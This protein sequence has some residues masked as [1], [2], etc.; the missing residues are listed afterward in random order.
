MYLCL[1]GGYC[2]FFAGYVYCYCFIMCACALL[3]DIWSCL[4]GCSRI[5][6]CRM[7]CVVFIVIGN[8]VGLVL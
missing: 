8:F 1:T 2:V 3:V 5:R 7:F 4:G 6:V